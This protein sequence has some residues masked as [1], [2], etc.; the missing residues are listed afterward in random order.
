MKLWNHKLYSVLGF[1]FVVACSSVAGETLVNLKVSSDPSY[2]T[3]GNALNADNIEYTV[4]KVVVSEIEFEQGVDCSIDDDVVDEQEI[5]FE[6]EGP[7]VVNLLNQKAIPS[8]DQIKIEKATYCKFKFKLDKLED[9]EVTEGVSVSDNIVDYSVYIEGTYDYSTPFIVKFDQDEEFEMESESIEGLNFTNGELNT[10]F[11]VFD[12]S[13]L[14]EGIADLSTLD[15]V[16]GVVYIDKDNNQDEYDLIKE[17]LKKFSKLQKDSDDNDE[18][19]DDD[20][21]IAEGILN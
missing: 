3:I 20:D 8:F 13:K 5:E 11:L 4:A 16:D 10:I 7:F 9:D 1:V 15:D 19:D 17:N 21:V 2:T 6:Y 12:L 14:F 18:L